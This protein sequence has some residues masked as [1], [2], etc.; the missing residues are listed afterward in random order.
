MPRISSIRDSAELLIP[1]LPWDRPRW[2]DNGGPPVVLLHGLG[3]GWR[4]MEPMAR[5]LGREGYSTLNLP[6][7]STRMPIPDLLAFINR[8]VAKIAAGRPV[9]FVTHSL[10]GI[11]ARALIVDSPSWTPGR[12]AMLAPPHGG[13]EIVDWSR[14][15]PVIQRFLGPA[16]RSL[17]SDDFPNKLPELPENAEVAVIMGKRRSISVF[18]HL[19]EEDNDGIVSVSRGKIRGLCGFTVINADHTFIQMHPEAIR[20]VL[21][22]LK[23]GSLPT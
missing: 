15:Y 3:R 5:A 22:F 11:L 6:Y 9:N 7:P 21:G 19:L 13:S 23:S 4:A 10:G 1:P 2:R 8:E 17:G 20:L 12:I 18:K 16:G 14:S